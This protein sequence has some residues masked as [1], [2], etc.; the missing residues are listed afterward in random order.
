PRSLKAALNTPQCRQ[1]FS[2]YGT[3]KTFGTSQT[4][5][6]LGNRWGKLA[7]WASGNYQKSHSQ[8]LAY[9][10]STSFPNGT[11]GGF[12]EKNKLGAAAN[13]LGAN[14]LLTTDMAN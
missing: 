3:S 6:N 10:T 13:V 11:T 14:G 1:P 2:L 9:V 4:T 7:V 5:A 12:A 8:P